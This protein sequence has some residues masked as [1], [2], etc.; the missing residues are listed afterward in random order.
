MSRQMSLRG[1]ERVLCGAVAFA[2]VACSGLAD[3]G[4]TYCLTE[5]QGL[6]GC[7]TG[8]SSGDE[9]P[10][11]TGAW[12]CL[13]Q[14]PV[15]PPFTPGNLAALILP[16]LEWG[17]RTPL[18][19]RGLTATLCP[20]GN[21]TCENPLAAPITIK[22]GLLGPAVGTLP[23]G[24]AGVP[25]QEG[26]D[27]FI[28]FDVAQDPSM[29]PVPE[30][31]QF[32]STFLY[33][34]GIIAGP[35]SRGQPVLMFQRRFRQGIVRD[36]FPSADVNQVVSRGAVAVGV[37]DCDG[38]P[39]DNA[40]VELT[41]EGRPAPE[42]LPF[43]LPPSRI[44]LPQTLGQPL[45]TQATGSAGFLNVPLGYVVVTAYQQDGGTRIGQVQLGSVAGQL[46]IGAVRPDFAR[47]ADITGSVRVEPPPTSP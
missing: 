24:A 7:G 1:A 47:K 30:D 45:V 4:E 37:Y 41:T 25:L 36:T 18:M 46:T 42:A 43:I 3:G 31:Q 38:K 32:A 19:D 33:L 27:G 9:T 10:G 26:F 15:D 13:D 11:G 39:V 5:G 14:T 44:P 22:S 35:V 20:T 17:T 21:V 23:P 40:R 12:W 29:P 2:A 6:G 8:G 16:V 34:N 28:K